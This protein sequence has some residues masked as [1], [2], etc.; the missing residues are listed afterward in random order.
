[1]DD[2]QES[3]NVLFIDLIEKID[4]I[5]TMVQITPLQNIQVHKTTY[6]VHLIIHINIWMHQDEEQEHV[7]NIEHNNL[8]IC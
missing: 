1:M 7:K 8:K 3:K 5:V 6:L 4:G 2:D